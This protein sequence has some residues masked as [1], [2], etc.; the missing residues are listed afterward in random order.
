MNCERRWYISELHDTSWFLKTYW[1][2]DK[3]KWR[4]H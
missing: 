3:T 4:F 1:S 2:T